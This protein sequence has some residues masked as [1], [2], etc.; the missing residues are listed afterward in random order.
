M[1][2]QCIAIST[3]L[4]SVTALRQES[5]KIPE[6]KTIQCLRLHK[7][8]EITGWEDIYPVPETATAYRRENKSKSAIREFLTTIRPKTPAA[9]IIVKPRKKSTRHLSIPVKD[10]DKSLFNCK[11]MHRSFNNSFNS[12]TPNLK[13]IKSIM[14]KAKIIKMRGTIRKPTYQLEDISLQ[15]SIKIQSFSSNAKP[16]ITKINHSYTGK[17]VRIKDIYKG[18]ILSESRLFE[19]FAIVD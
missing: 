7:T 15:R 13:H 18:L 5:D 9:V 2:S 6:M 11:P 8:H 1:S 17:R 14:N 16:D 4:H 3:E 12:I 10:L 19:D